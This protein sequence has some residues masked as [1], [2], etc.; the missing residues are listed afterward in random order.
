MDRAL[1]KNDE[2]QFVVIPVILRSCMW[3]HAP[4]AKLQGLPKDMRAVSTWPDKDE[5]YVNIV[6]GIKAAVEALIVPK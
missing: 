6:E 1:E 5:A 3:Q 4:F 2:K